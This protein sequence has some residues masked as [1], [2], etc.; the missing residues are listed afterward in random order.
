MTRTSSLYK[1]AEEVEQNDWT[2]WPHHSLKKREMEKY[3]E[4]TDTLSVL[5]FP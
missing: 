3:V 1:D 5:P 2:T 4:A